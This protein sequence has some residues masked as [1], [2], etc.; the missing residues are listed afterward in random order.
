[1]KRIIVTVIK[2]RDKRKDEKK[3]NFTCTLRTHPGQQ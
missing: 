3:G 2:K 1:M